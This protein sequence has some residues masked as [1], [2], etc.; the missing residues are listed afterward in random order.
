MLMSWAITVGM[1]SF[2]RSFPTGSVP[3]KFLLSCMDDNPFLKNV[4]E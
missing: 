2:K 3:R 4:F 1:D